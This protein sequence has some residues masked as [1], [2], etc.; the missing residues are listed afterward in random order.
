MAAGRVS[1]RDVAREA[2]VSVTTVSHALNDK[3][4]L[5][6]QTRRRVREVAERLGYRPDPAARSLVSGKTRVLAVMA[7]LPDEPRVEF[8]DFAYYTELIGAAAGA[9]MAKEYALVVAPPSRA[10]L[11][12]ERV[13]LDGVMVIDPVDGEVALPALRKA[14]I[15]FVTVGRDPRGHAGDAVVAG[16]DVAATRDVLDH[17][18]AVGARRIAMIA[19]PPIVASA[20]DAAAAYQEWCREREVEPELVRP[21]LQDLVLRPQAVLADVIGRLS[22]GSGMPDAIYAPLE[23]LGVEVARALR[24]AGLRIPEDVMLATTHDAGRAAAFDPPLTTLGWDYKEYG[25]RAC[26]LLIDLVEGRRRAPCL[27][28]VAHH[29]TPRA[30]TAR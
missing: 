13:A 10:G 27:E 21:P 1:I 18:E 24:S 2:G 15:P 28:P 7:S 3:G 16:D 26:D 30:S 11:I 25:Q 4:R 12:W 22:F 14:R 23:R 9:A 8:S 19:I 20:R 17:L 29:I 6:P 5:N